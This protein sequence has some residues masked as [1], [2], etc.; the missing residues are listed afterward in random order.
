[1]S[2]LTFALS[3]SIALFKQRSVIDRADI[4]EE[5]KNL[6]IEDFKRVDQIDYV[7]KFE[8]KEKE[9]KKGKGGSWWGGK[10]EEVEETADTTE[11]ETDDTKIY[12]QKFYFNKG[13]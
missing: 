12:V 4:D 8:A 2:S 11:D 13:L 10:E 9:M 3:M 5:L 6:K 1:M 7:A